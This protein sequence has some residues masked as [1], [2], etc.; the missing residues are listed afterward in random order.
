MSGKV[1][2]ALLLVVG[3]GYLCADRIVGRRKE[4]QLLYELATAMESMEGMIR[5]EKVVL[6]VA[7]ERQCSREN[8]GGMFSHILDLMKDEMTLQEAWEK[9]V[10]PFPIAE[11]IL[12]RLEFSG[13]ETRII[14]Q[15]HM[16]VQQLRQRAEQRSARRGESERLS[17]AVCASAVGLLAILLF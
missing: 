16:V 7:L 1:V 8:C 10:C 6:P 12:C 13:D 17:V 11:D 2:G 3:G 14:G 15:L 9:G 5:W 4:I